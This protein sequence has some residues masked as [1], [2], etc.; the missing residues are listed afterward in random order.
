MIT[1][2]ALRELRMMIGTIIR[3]FEISIVEGQDL[4]LRFHIVPHFKAGAYN[5]GFRL[6][7]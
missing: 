6:R 2:F 4:E 5:V 3:R 7:D 1:R